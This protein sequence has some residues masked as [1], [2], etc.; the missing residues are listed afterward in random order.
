MRMSGRKLRQAVGTGIA[1]LM[2]TLG[3]SSVGAAAPGAVGNINVVVTGAGASAQGSAANTNPT[4][5]ATNYRD[6]VRLRDVNAPGN[7]QQGG[8]QGGPNGQLGVTYD[9]CF[10]VSVGTASNAT[11]TQTISVGTDGISPIGSANTA[12]GLSNPIIA[13]SAYPLWEVQTG[14]PGR[15]VFVVPPTLNPP[16]GTIP[17]KAYGIETFR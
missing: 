1:A 13:P 9:G 8:L 4:I 17:A 6:A 7:G 16:N 5:T 15:N 14:T 12:C 11:P 2:L 10:Y 3:V